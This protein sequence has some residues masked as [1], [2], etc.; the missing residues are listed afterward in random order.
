MIFI[1]EPAFAANVDANIFDCRVRVVGYD[2]RL[3]RVD[4]LSLGFVYR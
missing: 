2:S 3:R 4:D 1:V